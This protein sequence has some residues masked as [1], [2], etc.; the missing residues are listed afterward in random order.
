MFNYNGNTV[1]GQNIQLQQSSTYQYV[2]VPFNIYTL[3]DTVIIIIQPSD[4]QDNLPSVAGTTMIIDEIQ[5]KSSPLNTNINQ[6]IKNNDNNVSIYPN[7]SN[8]EFYLKTNS[9]IKTIEIY[10][11]TGELVYSKTN[12]SNKNNKINKLDLSYLKKG[13]YYIKL[14]DNFKTYNQ[15][16]II[17]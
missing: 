14:S 16:I 6:F 17:Q 15:K 8:G 13:I 3:V 9:D 2:E 12:S 4:W 1:Y 10:N 7:P 11:T 5:F